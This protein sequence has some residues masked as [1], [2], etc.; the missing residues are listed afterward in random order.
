LLKASTNRGQINTETLGNIKSA[1]EM[2]EEDPMSVFMYALRAPESRRQ[3]PRRFKVFLDYLGLEGSIED[4]ARQFVDKA[5]NNPKWFHQSLMNFIVFQKERV[6]RKE[7]S[8]GTIGNYYKAIKLFCEM[9]FDQPLIN[10]KK[11]ARG[12][13]RARKFALDRIPTIEEISKLCE[14]PDRRIKVIIYTMLSSG[15]R[16]GAFDSLQWKHV[17]PMTNSEGEIVAAKL[18]VYAGDPIEEYYT[19]CTPEAYKELKSWIDY[20]EQ[21]GEE[22]SGESWVMRDIWQTSGMD[23]GAKFGLA[24][25]PKKLESAAVKRI[26]ERA[27]WEQGIRK[28]LPKGVK[29]HEWKAAHGFRKYFKTKAELAMLPLHVEMLLGHDTGLSMSYYRPSDKTLLEDYMKAVDELTIDADKELL[30]R[31]VTDLEQKRRDSEYIIQGKL[32][33]KEKEIEILKSQMHEVLTTL[34]MAKT[35]DGI[36]AKNR[37]VLDKKRRVTF[38]YIGEDNELVNVKIPIDS[39]EVH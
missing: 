10:W 32:R 37:T 29:H 34:R 3:Y 36:I 14:Y 26:I 17:T 1:K 35:R 24:A 28:P 15:I 19:F 9:N 11:I 18:I 39:V 23:Y 31:Q 5:R 16:V 27:L 38:G 30:Q 20:R 13:P 6:G 33:E 21:C 12:L 7:I 22:I 2:T 4:Q 8:E 25:Q